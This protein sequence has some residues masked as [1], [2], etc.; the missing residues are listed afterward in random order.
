MFND[1]NVVDF[2]T[3]RLVD[4]AFALM[5]GQPLDYWHGLAS[6]APRLA[7]VGIV[8]GAALAIAGARLLLFA[9]VLL[10]ATPDI[11]AFVGPAGDAA[12]HLTK[13]LYVVGV[14]AFAF[15]LLE[16]T[17]KL[18]FGR[19]AG[20]FAFATVVGTTIALLIPFLPRRR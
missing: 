9:T 4:P 1:F 14:L 13:V 20:S 10:L 12:A 11:V 2:L 6:N 16:A 19:D 8:L 7:V 3:Q 18:V 15:G 5:T 17:L